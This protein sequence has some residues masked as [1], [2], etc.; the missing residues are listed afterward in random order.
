MFDLLSLAPSSSSNL[1]MTSWCSWCFFSECFFGLVRFLLL[2]LI[3]TSSTFL[4]AEC[5]FGLVCFLIAECFLGLVCFLGV[6][7]LLGAECFFGLVCLL[8]AEHFL[9]LVCFLGAECFFGL[10]CFFFSHC[11]LGLLKIITFLTEPF[12]FLWERDLFLWD[13]VLFLGVSA[14]LL[15]LDLSSARIFLDGDLFLLAARWRL[16]K[17]CLPLFSTTT[18]LS[19]ASLW[20]S[21][22]W[23]PLALLPTLWGE[24]AASFLPERFCW[25]LLL[26]SLLLDYLRL[27]AFC[28]QGRHLAFGK[29][30]SWTS[31][32][33]C[34]MT[35]GL[36]YPSI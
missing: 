13:A 9:G 28:S 1:M 22:E 31:C 5:F 11:F 8:G 10:V 30:R 4:G 16:S 6:M 26:V 27:P 17:L 12:L 36:C 25:F 15:L 29:I 19:E 23:A 14:L 3:T 33:N 20:L 2:C 32:R 21:L 7:S 24:A 18:I 34:L 35:P